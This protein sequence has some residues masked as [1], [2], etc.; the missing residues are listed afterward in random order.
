MRLRRT[1][2][3]HATRHGEETSKREVISRMKRKSFTLIELLVV[4]AIIAILASLLLP[5]LDAAKESARISQCLG[6]QRQIAFFHGVYQL[7]WNNYCA[8]GR[9]A[10]RTWY[11]KLGLS[12]GYVYRNGTDGTGYTLPIAPSRPAPK[13]TPSMFICPSGRVDVDNLSISY[14]ESWFH[15]AN[16]YETAQKNDEQYYNASRIKVQPGSAAKVHGPSDA[17][18]LYESVG[19]CDRVV[20]GSG[21]TP[22]ALSSYTGG[23]NVNQPMRQKDLYTGRHKLRVNTLY[24]D[25]HSQTWAV[26]SLMDYASGKGLLFLAQIA[27]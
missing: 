25:G 26:N 10:G 6:Q 23:A 18:Y 17:V 5:A 3:F 8:S 1:T 16:G 21:S 9:G 22:Y 24:V 2:A 27:Y 15:Y 7:D 19:T 13:S 14:G 11:K 12:N 4:I 20:A